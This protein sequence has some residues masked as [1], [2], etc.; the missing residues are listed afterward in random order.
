MQENKQEKSQIKQNILLFLNSKGVTPYEFYKKS[1]VTRG[2]LAQNNGISEDNLAR[3]RA[4]APEVNP[5]WLLTGRGDMIRHDVEVERNMQSTL[6]PNGIPLVPLSAKAGRLTE[7][8]SVVE[9]EC[10]RY[11]VPAFRGADFMITVKGNSMFPSFLSGDI[12]ACKR[13][14]M[15]KLFFQWGHVYVLDTDQGAIVKRIQKSDEKENIKV[16]SDNP[17]YAPFE[18]PITSIYSVA[19][20]IGVIRLV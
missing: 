16:V 19:L 17:Q 6:P 5:E 1:G 9:Y 12:I 14:T 11:V 3:F 10:E 7:D 18:L 4:Y 8:I 15:D 13:V 20:V 2:I